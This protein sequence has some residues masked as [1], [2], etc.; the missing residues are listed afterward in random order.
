MSLITR[1]ISNDK[2]LALVLFSLF[3]LIFIFSNDG[4]RFSSDEDWAQ[5]QTIKLVTLEPHPLYEQDVSKRFY[6]HPTIYPPTASWMQHSPLCNH[7]LLCTGVSFAWSLTEYPFVFI[8]YHLQLLTTDS[9]V[10]D[11]EDFEDGHYVYWR[12]SLD[13]N[14]TFLEV[15][16]GPFYTALSISI[17]Y[18]IC[19]TYNF[20]NKTSL[21]LTF[22]LAL[23]TTFWAYSQTSFSSVSSI[24]F[25]LLGFFLFR[26]FENKHSLYY[27]IL[28]A[29]SLGFSFMIRNDVILFI[30]P[31][32]GLFLIKLLKE[33]QKIIK[34]L[35]YCLPLLLF[36][37]SWK[38]FSSLRYQ[39]LPD[40][41]ELINLASP[42]VY[43]YSTSFFREGI[44]G[45]LF[46]PGIGL[47]IFVP[48]LLTVFFSF[49]S[50]FNKN[51]THLFFFIT[52]T[53]SFVFYF[54]T[55]DHWH[56]LVSWGPRYL[57][58]VIP[59]MLIPLGASIEQRSTKFLLPIILILGGSGFLFNIAYLIQDVSW[60]VWGKAGHPEGL[61]GLGSYLTDL[62]IHPATI[63]TFEYS[64][65]THSLISMTQNL[66]VDIFMNK[67]LGFPLFLTSLILILIAHYFIIKKLL[68]SNNLTHKK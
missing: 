29:S 31:L 67:V 43:Q 52:V 64:Q 66:H 4:H 46:S 60:F 54:G 42:L 41:N 22:L 14:F 23:S 39:N 6:E 68:N 17:F 56:G 21:I 65:L 57:L 24:S 25:L 2:K 40:T 32:T 1:Q 18:L 28:G 13:P 20:N 36:F 3:F 63:W 49:P 7:P 35:S 10:W 47:L 53:F 15:F 58:P 16:F 11:F 9:V 44:L 33:K 30:I 19:R 62:Y 12:N 27:L 38:Y 5:M 61:F 59:F 48:I 55:L 51:K 45:L 50:F 26:R 34:L 37:Y 8:N